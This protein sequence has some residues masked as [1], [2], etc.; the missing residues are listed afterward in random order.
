MQRGMRIQILRQADYTVSAWAGGVTTQLAIWP[1]QA[2]YAARSFDGRVS[3]AVVGAEESVFTRLPDYARHLAILDGQLRLRHN[4]GGELTLHPFTPHVF[5]GA[6][7]TRL[8]VEIS[9]SRKTS[10]E[11]FYLDT[12]I[13]A[14]NYSLKNWIAEVCHSPGKFAELHYLLP[15]DAKYRRLRF[16]FG[17]KGGVA[18]AIRE[19]RIRRYFF[20]EYRIPAERIFQIFTQQK[21]MTSQSCAENAAEFTSGGTDCYFVSDPGAFAELAPPRVLWGRLA[22]VLL[23]DALVVFLL[24]V[25]IRCRGR[26]RQSAEKVTEHF[27]KHTLLWIIVSVVVA[28]A[29]LYREF[30]FGSAYYCYRDVGSDT[31]RSYLPSYR[32]LCENIRA[33]S[34]HMMLLQLGLQVNNAANQ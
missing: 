13:S 14:D 31:I 19:I 10:V 4:G 7:E 1:P 30:I 24:S 5:D 32:F 28:F 18:F 2:Q 9:S 12:H 20:L 21:E 22:I 11:I 26:V 29:F 6:D 27:E 3:S 16:D 17:N 33:G 25:C 34:L 15:G 8:S 23:V